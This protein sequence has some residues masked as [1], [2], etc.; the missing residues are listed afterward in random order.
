VKTKTGI[1]KIVNKIN[2]N[3]YYGSATTSFTKRWNNHITYLNSGRHRN[4]HLQNTWNKYGADNFEFVIVLLCDPENCLFYEQLFLDR[5]WD[6]C[7]N[8]YNINPKAENSLGVKRSAEAREKIRKSKLGNKCRLETKTSP[9]AIANMKAAQ[10][11]AKLKRIGRKRSDESKNNMSK[12]MMGN[13]NGVGNKANLGRKL[14]PETRKKMSESHQKRT[15]GGK[16]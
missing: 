1:Y 7:K 12:A 14:S 15:K 11:I 9:E 6:G 5:Y 4:I 10:V 13:K 16:L 8:C 2:R 3:F